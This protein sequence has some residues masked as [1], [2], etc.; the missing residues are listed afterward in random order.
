MVRGRHQQSHFA[1][2]LGPIVL[3]SLYWRKLTAIGAFAGMVSGAVVVFVWGNIPDLSNAMYEIV[4]G[5]AINLLVAWLVS[6]GTYRHN[7][8][9]QE[10][11]TE[12]ENELGVKVTA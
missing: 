7:E 4:P 10:E 5:F 9:V 8:Q 3:L 1:V 11:F 6:L 2:I 12:M